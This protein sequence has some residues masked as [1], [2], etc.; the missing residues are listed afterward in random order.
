MIST[1]LQHTLQPTLPPIR[2]QSLL[3]CSQPPQDFPPPLS[4]RRVPEW[5]DD[6]VRQRIIYSYRLIFR[7]LH[8]ARRIEVLA[9]IHGARLLP[10]EIHER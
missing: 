4:Y 9:V 8:D 10:D 2:L 1:Q 6:A 7:V 3:G 5:N